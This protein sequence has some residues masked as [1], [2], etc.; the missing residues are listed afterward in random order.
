MATV[1]ISADTFE[2]TIAD[3]D[4]VLVDFWADWCGPCKRFAPVYDK[5]SEEHDDVV[6][7]KLDTEANQELSAG[8]GITGIP[9]LMAFREG[10]LVFNQAGALPAP[11]LQE[12]VRA[13]K[14]LDMDQVHAEV[15]KM[16]AEAQGN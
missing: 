16:K 12:V 8:L 14:D 6:F 2:Q 13:V 15:E 7:A 10:V 4:I 11:Q 1:D 5:T 3:N 9:T